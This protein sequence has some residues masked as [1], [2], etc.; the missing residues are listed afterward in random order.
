[1]LHNAGPPPGNGGAAKGVE[2]SKAAR[3]GTTAKVILRASARADHV[4]VPFA[5]PEKGHAG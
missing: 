1:M 3:V 4:V 2:A 5:L